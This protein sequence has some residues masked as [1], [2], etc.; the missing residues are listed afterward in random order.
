MNHGKAFVQGK[1]GRGQPALI[2]E[3]RK[4][5][6]FPKCVTTRTVRWLAQAG[7]VPEDYDGDW[8]K[9]VLRCK[10][11]DGRIYRS[12]Q[13]LC[14]ARKAK[15]DEGQP[16]SHCRDNSLTCV[17]KVIPPSKSCRA[18]SGCYLISGIDDLIKNHFCRFVLSSPW[19]GF[20][21]VF[22]PRSFGW[23]FSSG[24]ALYINYFCPS[25]SIVIQALVA[26]V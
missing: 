7:Q 24:T 1:R 21:H 11:R 9:V 10:L 3:G 6:Y 23:R 26:F 22:V 17:Y 18:L 25:L 16:C 12:I 13:P 15:C 19:P 8:V 4:I 2:L 20:L 5:W 14:R